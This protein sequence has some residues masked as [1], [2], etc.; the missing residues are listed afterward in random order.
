[1]SSQA[2]AACVMCN[3]ACDILCHRTRNRFSSFQRLLHISSGPIT[4]MQDPQE[5][6]SYCESRFRAILNALQTADGDR[7]RWIEDGLKT[8]LVSKIHNDSKN[9]C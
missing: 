5:V 4:N 2:G 1:M 9:E 8:E 7:E 6:V 3:V